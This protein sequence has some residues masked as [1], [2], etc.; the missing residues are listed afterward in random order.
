MILR[1]LHRPILD[2]SA[3]EGD[4]PTDHRDAEEYDD[5]DDDDDDDDDDDVNGDEDRLGD[6][7]ED[8]DEDDLLA[9][10]ADQEG[11]PWPEDAPS[12]TEDEP[13]V[14]LADSDFVDDLPPYPVVLGSMQVK[15]AVE[16]R[17]LC[18]NP[19]SSE[20]ELLEAYHSI[21]LSVFMTNICHKSPPL[22]SLIDGFIISTG[23]DVSMRFTPPHLISN[24][25]SKI[26]YITLFS[27]LTDV[28]K[29]TNPHE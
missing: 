4:H 11:S 20:D 5:E 13:A 24:H 22:H 15:R 18:A 2:G 7:G 25:L 28:M 21:I 27:I 23:I 16:L 8:Q 6:E 29:T 17:D 12:V 9:S 1:A 26:L 10:R 19:N 3:M 14:E